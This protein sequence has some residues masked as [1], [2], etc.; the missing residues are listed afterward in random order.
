MASLFDATK[1]VVL[2]AAGL[3]LWMILS[4]E[5]SSRSTGSFC[6]ISTSLS[7][8]LD[9]FLPLFF[10]SIDSFDNEAEDDLFSPLS[11]L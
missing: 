2:E 11:M 1:A 3:L 4:T 8:V 7:W 5:G 10:E 9:H 6:V